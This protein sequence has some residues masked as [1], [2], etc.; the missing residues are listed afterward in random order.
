MKQNDVLT[1]NNDFLNVMFRGTPCIWAQY[2]YFL[3][4][5][6]LIAM[7]TPFIYIFDGAR[8]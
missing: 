2:I 6:V 8:G 4:L 7:N 5:H 3:I 1:K